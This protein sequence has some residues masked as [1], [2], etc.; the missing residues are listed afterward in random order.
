MGD[1]LTLLENHYQFSMSI[2]SSY[3]VALQAEFLKS[4]FNFAQTDT[5]RKDFYFDAVAFSGGA[6]DGCVHI[7]QMSLHEL[8]CPKRLILSL[9]TP[10]QTT[11][12]SIA[13]SANRS[14]CLKMAR[15]TPTTIR[16]SV[17]A[18]C[19]T[20]TSYIAA[21]GNPQKVDQKMFHHMFHPLPIPI[22]IIAAF[23][24][25]AWYG[26]C[27]PLPIPNQSCSLSHKSVVWTLTL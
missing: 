18:H 9:L 6:R 26:L 25:R 4:N 7:F 13:T 20:L 3:F 22:I 24:T 27:H 10:A 2:G 5:A 23:P 17:T 19:R 11:R 15:F 1:K 14:L 12:P 8:V 21:H 16:F